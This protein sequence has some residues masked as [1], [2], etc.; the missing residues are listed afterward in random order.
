MS[1]TQIVLYTVRISTRNRMF[2]YRYAGP[3]KMADMCTDKALSGAEELGG[4]GGGVSLAA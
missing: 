4:G 2:H 1:C 3:T